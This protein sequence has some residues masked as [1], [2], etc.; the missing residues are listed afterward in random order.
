MV[1][2]QPRKPIS[3]ALVSWHQLRAAE[4]EGKRT[5]ILPLSALPAPGKLYGSGSLSC[6]HLWS[7]L[8][9]VSLAPTMAVGVTTCPILRSML[10]AQSSPFFTEEFC[11][12]HPSNSLLCSSSPVPL[13]R[14]RE[15][16]L[17]VLKYGADIKTQSSEEHVK[18]GS[19]MA[20]IHLSPEL[21]LAPSV[22]SRPPCQGSFS[23]THRSCQ[24]KHSRLIPL[25]SSL[26]LET[27]N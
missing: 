24:T 21:C 9:P 10:F 6:C 19:T 26:F 15:W 17:V 4:Q 12:L 22:L 14:V 20:Q 25:S 5:A 16:P 27:F 11:S 2:E 7:F 23:G 8:G 3:S 13:L 18:L 1:E